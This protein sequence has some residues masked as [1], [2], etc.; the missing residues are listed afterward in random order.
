MRRRAIAQRVKEV[1]KPVQAEELEDLFDFS[2][3]LVKAS[4]FSELKA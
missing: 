2:D 1:S 3:K 4:N